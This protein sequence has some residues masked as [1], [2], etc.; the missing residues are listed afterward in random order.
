MSRNFPL[1]YFASHIFTTTPTTTTS[2][3]QV[4][5]ESVVADV[6]HEE[7]GKGQNDTDGKD[8]VEPGIA[9][10]WVDEEAEEEEEGDD[11]EPADQ[12]AAQDAFRGGVQQLHGQLEGD[13]GAGTGQ[14]H[15]WKIITNS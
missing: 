7:E 10:V 13:R 2:S 6:D 12:P 8:I 3:G 5:S 15:A 1:L 14:T 11:V 4:H 9:A